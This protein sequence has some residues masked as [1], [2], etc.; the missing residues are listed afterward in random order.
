MR[1]LLDRI[2]AF[3]ASRNRREKIMLWLFIWAGLL[4]WVSEIFSAQKEI[5]ERRFDLDAKISEVTLVL[6]KE[7]SVSDSLAEEQRKIDFKKTVSSRELQKYVQDCAETAGVAYEISMPQTA[8]FDRMKVYSIKIN[9]Q[10]A[11]IEQI[12]NFEKEIRKYEPYVFMQ[13]ASL[14]ASGGGR[15]NARYTVSSFEFTNETKNR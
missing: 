10:K 9:C 5:S 12:I 6:S 1:K 8:N 7:K 4:I 15:I 13:D 3:Y 11:N 14:A 2:A